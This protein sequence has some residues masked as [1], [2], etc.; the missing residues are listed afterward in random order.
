MF[1]E[2]SFPEALTPLALISKHLT[3]AQ[4]AEE[5]RKLNPGPELIAVHI[6]SR[7]FSEVVTELRDL[8]IPKLEIGAFDKPYI[9]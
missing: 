5:A 3:P 4:F 8:G 6:K 9:F 7:Y 2:A 1:L